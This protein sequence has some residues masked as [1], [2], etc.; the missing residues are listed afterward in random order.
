[1]LLVL[2]KLQIKQRVVIFELV[3]DNI[4]FEDRVSMQIRYLGADTLTLVMENGTVLDSDKIGAPYGGT[5]VIIDSVP[6]T[7]TVRDIDDNSVIENARVLLEAD[8]GG[9]LTAGVDILTGL[10]NVSGVATTN[11]RYTSDQPIYRMDKKGYIW[12]SV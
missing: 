8:T 3:L 5:I 2:L 12:N 10:T 1:M 6:V 4:T 9:D 7:I 11:L